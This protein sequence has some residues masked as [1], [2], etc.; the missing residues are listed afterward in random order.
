MDVTHLIER[1]RNGE[2][3]YTQFKQEPIK[4]QDL[5]KEFVAF[6]NAKGGIII[7]GVADDGTIKGL[8]TEDIKKLEHDISNTGTENVSPPMYPTTQNLTVQD[9]RLILVSIE[10]GLSKPYATSSGTYYTKAGATKKIVSQDELKRLFVESHTLYAD[11][12]TRKD[13][14]INDL[15]RHAYRK[16][17]EQT[18]PKILEEVDSGKL[19]IKT[20][21]KNIQ[22]LKNT[23]LTLAGNLIFAKNPQSFFPDFCVDCCYFDGE[24]VSVQR[25]ISKKTINGRL[26]TLYEEGLS[27]IMGN[28][29]HRQEGANFNAR[30]VAE[31]HPETLTELIVNA[32]IHRDYYINAS[33]K[34]FI[35]HSRIEIISPGKIPNSLEVENIKSG[36]SIHRNPIISSICKDILP[37]SGIGSGIKRALSLTPDIEFINDVDNN[38]FKCI[39]PK[40]NSDNIQRQ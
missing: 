37:Y 25:F 9:A 12:M 30:A 40:H 26:K 4:V 36:I 31:I 19:D 35:F 15:D 18:H 34:I 2:D 24:D 23:H 38:I 17:L 33:V 20:T 10:E 16:Y 32:L 29:A 13:S 7:F 39:I 1:I 27:F 8:N 22:V 6:A 28:I 5:A 11:E 21:L 14:N 3:S